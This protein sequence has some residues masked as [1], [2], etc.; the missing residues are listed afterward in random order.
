MLRGSS[1]SSESDQL[2]RDFHTLQPEGGV[3]LTAHLETVHVRH[4]DGEHEHIGEGFQLFWT[5]SSGDVRKG[6]LPRAFAGRRS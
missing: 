6:G 3:E 4:E 2:A 5:I 1:S